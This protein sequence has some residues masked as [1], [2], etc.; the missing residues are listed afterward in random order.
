MA[1][2]I[3]VTKNKG[4]EDFSGMCRLL[5]EISG[6]PMHEVIDAEFGLVL[7]EAANRVKIASPNKIISDHNKQKI[8]KLR[9]PYNPTSARVTQKTIDANIAAQR[10]RS[11]NNGYLLYDLHKNKYPN[12]LWYEIRDR[13]RA[14]LAEKMAKAG[15]AAKHVVALAEYMGMRIAAPARAQ[16]AKN[17]YP[18]Q[19]FG[20]RS[21]SQAEY[22]IEGN[23]INRTAVVY[24]GIRQAIQWALR[25]RRRGFDRGMAMW[26]KGKV[27]LV[28]KRYPHLFGRIS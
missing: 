19:V 1:I 18:L 2:K 3:K 26:M 10:R 7:Q 27:R 4:F 15:I 24:G 28:A 13:R 8:T 12:W 17:D 22:Y 21:P 9:I 16:N 6:K 23:I 14:R 25:K 11:Q 20:S 5:S